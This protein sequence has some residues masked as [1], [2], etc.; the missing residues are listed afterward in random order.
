MVLKVRVHLVLPFD[1]LY[2]LTADFTAA[3]GAPLFFRESVLLLASVLVLVNVS[4]HE[5]VSV[6]A[7]QVESVEALVDASEVISVGE[8]LGG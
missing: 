8:R 4:L 1:M 3:H 7:N 5:P 2:V 6:E